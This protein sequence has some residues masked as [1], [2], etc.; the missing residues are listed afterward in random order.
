M[1]DDNEIPYVAIGNDELD[2]KTKARL[3]ELFDKKDNES[4]LKFLSLAMSRGKTEKGKT[5]HC[6]KNCDSL[7]LVFPYNKP[8]MCD[9]GGTIKYDV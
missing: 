8:R 7:Y 6:D 2:S 4:S 5:L 3:D 9:C 1:T